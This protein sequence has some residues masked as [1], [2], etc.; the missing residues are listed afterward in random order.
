MSQDFLNLIIFNEEF[1][2]GKDQTN[3]K[4]QYFSK[5][6]NGLFMEF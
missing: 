2:N 4:N 1:P 5:M 6:V 3:Q